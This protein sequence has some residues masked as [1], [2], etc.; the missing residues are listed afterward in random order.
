MINHPMN[1]P[2]LDASIRTVPAMPRSTSLELCLNSSS[3]RARSDRDIDTFAP[4]PAIQALMSCPHSR[5]H[6]RNPRKIMKQTEQEQGKKKAKKKGL[7]PFRHQWFYRSCFRRVLMDHGGDPWRWDPAARWVR[8]ATSSWGCST[9]SAMDMSGTDVAPRSSKTS[10]TS[11]ENG[12]PRV[13]KSSMSCHVM[14]SHIM[15]GYFFI[16]CHL[17]SFHAKC[18]FMS[19]HVISRQFMSVHFGSFLVYIFLAVARRTATQVHHLA[20]SQIC[21]WT[22]PT[23]L[24]MVSINGGTP[25]TLHG[26]F[27]GTSH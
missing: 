8:W 2:F 24:Q 17:M 12:A 3:R 4:L 15:S 7:S 14:S 9:P 23:D 27:H 26:L 1:S 25:K 5:N 13:P 22:S 19:R 16:S 6:S 21:H 11:V 18:H 20:L 10:K